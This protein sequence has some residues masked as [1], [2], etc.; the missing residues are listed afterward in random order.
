MNLSKKKLYSIGLIAITCLSIIFG[1]ALLGSIVGAKP[2]NIPVA[3]IVEDEGANLPNGTPF[4]VGALIAASLT[5]NEQLPFTW[6]SYSSEE[7][8]RAAIES[9]E[10]YGALVIP[11]NLSNDLLTILTEKAQPTNVHAIYNEGMNTQAVNV[12]KQAIPLIINE[13]NEAISTQLMQMVEATTGEGISALT[14]S[15]LRNPIGL[16]EEITHPIGERQAMGNAP[17]LLSQLV[18]VTSMFTALLLFLINR[19]LY[20]TESSFGDRLKQAIF[21]FLCAPLFALLIVWMS[22]QWY[23]IEFSA[24]WDVWIWLTVISFAFFFLQSMLLNLIGLP[25]MGLLV[26]LMFFSLPIVNM[27]PE[28]LTEATHTWI[29]SWSPLRI[30]ASSMRTV[31]YFDGLMFDSAQA[32]TLIG[33]A[34]GGAILLLLSSYLHRNKSNKTTTTR[35]Q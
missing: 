35:T 4:Q 10:L 31:L 13:A 5:S 17:G 19:K 20:P 11:E 6:M 29:Y 22:S 12:F 9:G 33:I 8:L 2:Q 7:E 23:G 34:I 3:L 1:A 25:A 16:E 24:V 21:G 14:A 27:A 32:L 28:F 26:L 30:A 18:W 15:T